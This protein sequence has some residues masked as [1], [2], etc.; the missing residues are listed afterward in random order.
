MSGVVINGL[1]GES[2]VF[3]DSCISWRRNVLNI[4]L[5]PSFRLPVNCVSSVGINRKCEMLTLRD[6]EESDGNEG[7]PMRA[8]NTVFDVPRGEVKGVEL[9][10]AGGV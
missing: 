6:C 10:E 2:I 5:L 8:A 1:R 7:I 4:V 9:V 3:K